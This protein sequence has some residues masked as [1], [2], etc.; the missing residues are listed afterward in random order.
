[1]GLPVRIFFD[2]SF[3]AVK[4]FSHW[5]PVIKLFTFCKGPK[6][7]EQ[8]RLATW[9]SILSGLFFVFSR[10][11]LQFRVYFATAIDSLIFLLTF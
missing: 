8:F 11:K 3:F 10:L 4:Y 5:G 6:P 2:T 7:Y 9:N 1:V